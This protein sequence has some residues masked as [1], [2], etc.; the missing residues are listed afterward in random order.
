MKF[1][2]LVQV[3]TLGSLLLA[4]WPTWASKAVSNQPYVQ[5]GPSGVFYARCIPAEA[6]GTKG[7]TKIYRVRKEQDEVV[8]N[9]DWFVM[10][11][12]VLAWS[13]IAGKVA[14][15]AL[16]GEPKA[17]PDKH[18][19]L[20][21]YLG[22]KLLNTYTT[23][24]LKAWGANVWP[25]GDHRARFKVLG[26]EQIPGTNEYVFSIEIEGKKFDFDILTGKP[27]KGAGTN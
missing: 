4:A 13:P 15:M 26:Q 12:V 14:V 17:V 5:S 10:N 23:N 25:R 19:E 3:V 20:S 7:S 1:R 27:Y 11:G 2:Q 24:D 16:G 22:G 9:Y 6:A 21:F 8:D 18:A